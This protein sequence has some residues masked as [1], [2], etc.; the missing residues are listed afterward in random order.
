MKTRARIAAWQRLRQQP[1]WKLL[2]ADNAPLTAALLQALL[3]DSERQLPASLL[4]ER[5]ARELEELRAHGHAVPRT[6]QAYV[7]DWLGAGW[8]ERRFPEGASEEL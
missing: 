1:T 7:A 2:A 8:L 6:A 4:H 3:L 5:L